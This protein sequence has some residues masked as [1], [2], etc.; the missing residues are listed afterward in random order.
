MKYILVFFSLILSFLLIEIF[1]RVFVDNGMNYEIEMQKYAIN[2]KKISNNPLIG[3]EHKKNK[4]IKLMGAEI[5]LDTYGF[6]NEYKFKNTNKKILMLGDSMTFGWGAR[7]PFSNLIN[8]KFTNID[9][10]NAGI[11]N[12]NTIMQIENF[13]SNQKNLFNYDVIILN[14]FINDLEKVEVK[15]I[16]Y[17][18]K[19]SLSYTYLSNKF[20]SLFIKNNLND[21]WEKFY[22]KNF[23]NKIFLE[24]T[25]KQIERLNTYCKEKNI[26]FYI[27]NIPELRNLKN[28]PFKE[29]TEIIKNYAL[30]NNIRFLDSFSAL[31]REKEESLWVSTSDS[32]ANDK[33]HKIIANYLINQIDELK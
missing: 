15:K 9:I 25:L 6:R 33:A 3:I 17:I 1:V 22:K 19:Y 8:E 12:T 21:D 14:F 24:E 29:E 30:K 23:L 28:Y 18:K 4:K 20:S 13:F 27:H 10:I 26:K 32:H 7:K 16:N 31:S 11:G 2:L 5:I